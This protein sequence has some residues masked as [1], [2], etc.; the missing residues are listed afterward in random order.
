MPKLCEV[1]YSLEKQLVEEKLRVK[2]MSDE[3]EN[4]MNQDRFR[5]LDG[6]DP[7]SYEMTAKIKNL[8]RRLIA[9]TEEVT[10]QSRLSSSR[11]SCSRRK[12]TS[13]SS[14]RS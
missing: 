11:S 9:K 6:S 4:P 10:A 1:N 8:Q 5:N 7:D 2:V 14:A 13:T 12:K 3:L